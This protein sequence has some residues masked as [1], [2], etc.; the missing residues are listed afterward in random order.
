V[1]LSRQR[2]PHLLGKTA[3]HLGAATPLALLVLQVLQRPESLGVNPIAALTDQLG[4]WALRLLLLTLTI[5]PLRLWTQNSA[6][7]RYRRLLGLWAAAYAGLHLLMY[8]A[9]DQRFAGAVLLE[10]IIKRPWIT[11][12]L[13]TAL[14]LL[15]LTVTSTRAL[16]RRLGRRWQ[17]L[18]YA[19]YPAA[20]GALW[21]YAW[22]VKKDL[23]APLSYAAI[24]VIL[25]LLRLAKRSFRAR[26]APATTP[27]RI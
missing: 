26:F 11:V 19:I 17:T 12:G 15:A 4:L 18:H 9:V 22:Q 20:A 7:L 25:M 16:M 1:V 3:A 2:W 14:L 27:G 13:A 8:V 5:T 21:H 24:F 10:D 6:W 23:R